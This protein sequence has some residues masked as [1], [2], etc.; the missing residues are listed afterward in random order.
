M[1]RYMD[2]SKW[3]KKE[4]IAVLERS[5]YGASDIVSARFNSVTDTGNAVFDIAFT[6]DDAPGGISQGKAFVFFNQA[7]EIVADF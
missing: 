2:L 6:D 7:G 5:G 3:T 4:L 1:E